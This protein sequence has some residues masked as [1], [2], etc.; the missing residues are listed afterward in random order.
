MDATTSFRFHP[1]EVLAG[2]LTDAAVVLVLGVPAGAV[3]AHQLFRVLSSTFVHGN[4]RLNDPLARALGWLVM[5]PD[6]HRI[7]HLCNPQGQHANLSGGLSL[8]DRVFG[9]YLAPSAPHAQEPAV[10]VAGYDPARSTSLTGLLLDPLK[11]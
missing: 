3:L 6:L 7:H 2:T 8:W 9:T 4:V 11:P 1:L 5:T 10:G